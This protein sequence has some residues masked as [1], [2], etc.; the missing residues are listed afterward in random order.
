[1]GF[2]HKTESYRHCWDARSWGLGTLLLWFLGAVKFGLLF[3][4]GE[5]LF[6]RILRGNSTFYFGGPTYFFSSSLSHPSPRGTHRTRGGDRIRSRF[7]TVGQRFPP[8]GERSPPRPWVQPSEPGLSGGTAASCGGLGAAE[9]LH[10]N[11]ATVGT[12]RGPHPELPRTAHF[13]DAL[14]L[15][16]T[17]TFLSPPGHS[18]G[19]PATSAWS[20][21]PP[22][23]QGNVS[24]F[25]R[26]L[27]FRLPVQLLALRRVSVSVFGGLL[28]QSTHRRRLPGKF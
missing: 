27:R 4:S 1:M 3:F 13:G 23:A 20:Q 9:E 28:W 18:L 8:L 12:G 17:R 26:R 19:F 14:D 24:G 15:S 2:I 11:F 25:S 5:K 7:C 10:R 21:G 16:R 6:G 22:C